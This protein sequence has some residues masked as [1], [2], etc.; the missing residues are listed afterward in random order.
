M[1]QK[2]KTEKKKERERERA[3]VGDNKGQLR[4][5]NTTLGGACKMSGPKH[6]R[7]KKKK[8]VREYSRVCGWPRLP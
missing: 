7:M 6:K 2:Q 1:G 8:K 3:K 4:V 5:A